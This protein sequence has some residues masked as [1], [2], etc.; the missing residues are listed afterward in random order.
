[1][2][3]DISLIII[4]NLGGFFRFEVCPYS[5][6]RYQSQVLL[7]TFRVLR[8]VAQLLHCVVLYTNQIYNKISTYGGN[9]HAPVGDPLLDHQ[10]THR[11][12]TRVGRKERKKIALKQGPGLPEVD[13]KVCLGWGGYYIDSSEMKRIGSVITPYLD[14]LT[15]S[16]QD[17]QLRSAQSR[18]SAE[19][20]T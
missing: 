16:D 15:Q 8:G 10:P 12:F 9:P 14:S 13:I 4:D 18:E 20:V 1:M 2:E 11:F 7:D 6:L 3:T 17:P 19:G 5:E